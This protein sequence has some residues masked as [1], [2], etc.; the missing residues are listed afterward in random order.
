[1]NSGINLTRELIEKLDVQGPRYTSYPT[2]VDWT[3]TFTCTD[4][5]HRLLDSKNVSSPVSVYIHIPFCDSQCYFCGCNTLIRKS[6]QEF[7]QHY[8]TYIRKEIALVT[9]LLGEKRTIK[10]LHIGG[11]T[12]NFL[13]DSEFTFLMKAIHDHFDFDSEAEISIEVDPRTLTLEQLRHIRS[14]GFNRISMGIQDFDETVQKAINR[15]QPLTIVEPIIRLC[16]ELAFTSVN[17]DL[18]YGLPFQTTK[19]LKET[20]QKIVDL[21]PDRIAFYSF[22]YLPHLKSYHALIKPENLPTAAEKIDL[23]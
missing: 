19:S 9:Q 17:V 10:Q 20:I 12:P 2:A 4:Y 14:L 13:R 22:G 5:T 3:P 11:G 16:R 21:S 8:L 6:K 1:M 23:F 18:I 15:I 7:A